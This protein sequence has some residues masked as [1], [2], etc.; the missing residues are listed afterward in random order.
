MFVES[1]PPDANVQKTILRALESGGREST[2][3][4]TKLPAHLFEEYDNVAFLVSRFRMPVRLG[5][6]VQ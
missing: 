1:R 2:D 4:R 5:D 6:L 3:N